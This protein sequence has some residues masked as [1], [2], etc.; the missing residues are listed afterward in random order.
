MPPN[1]PETIRD[2]AELDEALTRPSAAL[3]EFARTLEGP[4]LVLGAGGKM[5]PSLAVLA[6]RA[7][8][9]AGRATEVTAVSRFTSEGARKWL[10]ERGVR[11]ISCDLL[12]ASAVAKLPEAPNI[13]Y[14][15]GLK[16]GTAD[17]PSRTWAMNVVVPVRVAERYAHSRIVALST[18]NVYP[19]SPVARG[20]S[21]ETDSL[22]PLGE[23]ANSAIGRE[24]IFQFY[25]Q[26]E[27]MP[28]ALL[29]LFY[30][31]DLRYG[32]VMDI[33][34]KVFHG[35]SIDLA[36]GHFNTIWQGDAN[37]MILRSLD[38]ASAP[39]SVFNLCR[40]EICSVR[41]V[42]TRLGEI[43]NRQPKFN[44]TESETALIANANALASRL[45]PPATSMETILKWA[46]HWVSAG[47]RDLG[48]PTHFEERTGKY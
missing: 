24:R 5:G 27:K 13:I 4:L 20:G 8:A 46:A 1:F 43:F 47:G 44:G 38:L 10:E 2:E 14:L 6:K 7:A 34:R 41:A 45:G 12:D 21:V 36:N 31:V 26:R 30:A 9:A 17:D 32:V 25:S 23:Y 11:T 48:K 28:V 29:R 18:G 15:V 16:F 19:L 33:A 3:I 22:T 37:E 42:A 40:A 35:E 39:A